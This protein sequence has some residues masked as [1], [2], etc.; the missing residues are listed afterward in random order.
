MYLSMRLQDNTEGGCAKSMIIKINPGCV[1]RLSLMNML[2]FLMVFGLFTIDNRA[3]LNIST[4]FAL[5]LSVYLFCKE[6]VNPLSSIGEFLKERKSLLFFSLWCLFSIAFFTYENEYLAALELLFKDWRYPLV[7]WLMLIAFKEY[8]HMI[9][10][11]YVFSA[12]LTLS[13]I[14]LAVPIIRFLKNNPQELYLQLRYGFAFYVVM[15]FPFVLTS[16]VILKQ[17][18]LKIPLLAVAF[19]SFVFLLYTGSRGGIVSLIIETI[20]VMLILSKDI[21]KFIFSMFVIAVIAGVGLAAAYNIFP[22]VKGKIEQTTKLTNVTSSRDKILTQRYPLVMDSVKNNLFGIGYG[23]STYDQYL[24]DHNA[25]R[26]D[27]VFNS[28]TN[29][30]NLDEP[31]FIT[32]LYNVGFGGLILFIASIFVNIQAQIRS[33]KINKDVFS[34]SIFA[35]FVGYFLVYCMFEK[36][37]MEIYLIYTLLAFYLAN[38][39]SECNR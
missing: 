2:L 27:G 9:K 28:E 14:V 23:N 32:V 30:Y 13:Y 1:N 29:K 7:M 12:I 16:A 18:Y 37:F 36:M 33:I 17:R 21:K 5:L 31:L 39:K 26:E 10:K 11:T 4:A 6:K 20:I 34:V 3:I 25:P 8:L 19:L 22:Q 24:W 38:N 35:S 15:L